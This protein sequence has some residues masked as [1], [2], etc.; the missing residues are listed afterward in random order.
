MAIYLSASSIQ[1]FIKCPQKVFYRLKKTVPEQK[2]REMIMGQIAHLAIEQGWKNRDHAYS[3][4]DYE[5][6]KNGLRLADKTHLQYMI[7]LFFLNFQPRLGENDLIEY[8]FKIKLYEDVFIVGKI[9]RISKGNLFDW[10]TGKLPTK[11]HNDVQCIIY[12]WAFNQIFDKPPTSICLAGLTSGELLPYKKDEFYTREIFE[13]IIP[14]MIRTVKH[15]TYERLGL[16]NHSCFRCPWKE[17]CLGIG[18]VN[19]LDNSI[20]PE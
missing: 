5:T 16:F 15:D 10:K 18:E 8:N 2:S 3:I 4:I 17:G 7:D 11:L 20:T 1:D 12:D 14:R 19:E 6:R 9:D 13:N